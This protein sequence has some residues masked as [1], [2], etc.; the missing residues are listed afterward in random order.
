MHF[1]TI[2]ILREIKMETYERGILGKVPKNK[3]NNNTL[4][5][6]QYISHTS[7]E[8]TSCLKYIKLY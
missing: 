4:N 5:L 2:L 7:S 3:K 1:E 6:T 8:W